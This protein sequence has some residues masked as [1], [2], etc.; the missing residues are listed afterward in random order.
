MMR[1][2]MALAALLALGTG[3]GAQILDPP[4]IELTITPE[5]ART[6]PPA[7]AAE[8]VFRQLA[9][10]I[11]S[12]SRPPAGSDPL[13]SLTFATAPHR[14]GDPGICVATVIHAG[15]ERPDTP[16]SLGEP[17]VMA[18]ELVYKVVSDL[19]LPEEWT[20]EY[21]AAQDALCA[22]A[23]P[24][25]SPQEDDGGRA[26][27]FRVTGVQ[28]PSA[29][30]GILKQAIEGARTGGY[31][32][33]GCDEPD[34]AACSGPK[35]ILAGLDLANLTSIHISERG[36]N[37][38]RVKA[39]FAVSRTAYQVVTTDAEFIAV[40]GQTRGFRLGRTLVSTGTIFD[41]SEEP[42]G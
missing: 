20:P 17:G 9:G 32:D 25:V 23:G 6:L 10:R 29:G 18:T 13:T 8:I 38:V 27:F 19:D 31:S 42:E 33:I 11:H 35:A 2:A 12:M 21:A 1:I 36:E 14:F 34:D 26:F 7:E 4:R 39:D 41:I 37:R 30:A 22:R 3:A 5:Q 24:V 16:D 40:P 15:R 28:A